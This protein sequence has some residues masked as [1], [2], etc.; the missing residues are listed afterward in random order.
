MAPPPP[1]PAPRAAS[2]GTWLDG[3]PDV[4]RRRDLLVQGLA[5]G[6]IRSTSQAAL[7]TCALLE[8]VAQAEDWRTASVLLRRIKLVG[9]SVVR[10][11]PGSLCVANIIRRALLIVREEYARNLREST[12]RR[13]DA[14][15]QRSLGDVLAAAPRQ[16]PRARDDRRDVELPPLREDVLDQLRALGDEVASARQTVAA[17]APDLIGVGSVVLTLGRSRGVAAFLGK[18]HPREVVVVDEEGQAAAALQRA[19]PAC[20]ITRVTSATAAAVAGRC[21][22]AVVGCAAALADGGVIAPPGSRLVAEACAARGKPVLALC[23]L[24]K[25]APLHHPGDTSAR[26]AVSMHAPPAAALPYSC[27]PCD[28]GADPLIHPAPSVRNPRAD[29]V[30]PDLVDL[31]VTNAGVHAPSYAPRLLAEMYAPEDHDL[32]RA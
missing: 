7:A 10:K 20:L 29:A 15:L 24:Y 22:V 28:P 17:N 14:G 18:A 1:P 27:V 6:E 13:D 16:D 21:T 11:S 25:L 4:R 12:S 23:A 32:L 30:P 26:A 31:L 19:L 9:G 8:S 2:D 3:A 5:T